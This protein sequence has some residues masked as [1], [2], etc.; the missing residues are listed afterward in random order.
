MIPI[1]SFS[2]KPVKRLNTLKTLPLPIN[3]TLGDHIFRVR[4]NK[5]LSGREVGEIIKTST[6]NISKWELNRTPVHP[7]HVKNVIEFLEY[8]PSDISD[9]EYLGTKIQLWK[10]NREMSTIAF[11]ELVKVPVVNVEKIETNLRKIPL[12]ILEKI[13][14]VIA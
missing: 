2:L 1:C 10:M 9:F 12:N 7:K 8:T 14:C 5:G 11:S 3:G 4:K 13:N 6:S